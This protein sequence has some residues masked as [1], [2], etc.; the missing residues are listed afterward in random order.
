YRRVHDLLTHESQRIEAYGLEWIKQTLH[1]RQAR[2][3]HRL[4]TA[5]SMLE[6]HGAIDWQRGESR[7][8]V[9]GPLP[10]RLGDP[11]WLD[12]KRKRDQ[13]KLQ[14]LVAY[15]NH[16]G[17]RKRYIHEYFGLPYGD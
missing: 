4:E 12:E 14:A 5:L 2:H 9:L 6:R 7:V 10:E 11:S 1:D 15:A 16:E 8:E 13:M 17:D 3:D